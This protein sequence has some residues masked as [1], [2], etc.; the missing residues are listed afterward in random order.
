[1]PIKRSRTA[2]SCAHL[3]K[4]DTG[5]N[6]EMRP[7]EQSSSA[8]EARNK[9]ARTSISVNQVVNSSIT[10]TAQLREVIY[11]DELQPPPP[12]HTNPTLPPVLLD[13][14]NYCK[15]RIGPKED[16]YMNGCRGFEVYCSPAC[17]EKFNN[18]MIA[19]GKRSPEAEP[20]SDHL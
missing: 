9:A 8:I 4:E 7:A 2:R 18:T 17:R 20:S 16:R 11:T 5:P 3:E 6:V 13:E 15:K 14:C 1:M 19:A 10:P 12:L